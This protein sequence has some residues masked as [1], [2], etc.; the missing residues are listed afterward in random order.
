M[1]HRHAVD[2]PILLPPG[3]VKHHPK[4]KVRQIDYM[5]FSQQQVEKH[6]EVWNQS[7]WTLK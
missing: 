7:V 3:D 5:A 1:R 6:D 4:G 2:I